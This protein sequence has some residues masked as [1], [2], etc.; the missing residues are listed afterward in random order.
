MSDELEVPTLMKG[1]EELLDRSDRNDDE[2]P[3]DHRM[4]NSNGLLPV[5]GRLPEDIHHRGNDPLGNPIDLRALS[6]LLL[7]QVEEVLELP[8]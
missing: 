5:H 6:L 1:G 2:S 7:N 8:A 3:K 4:E